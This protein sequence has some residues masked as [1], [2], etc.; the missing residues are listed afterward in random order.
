MFSFFFLRAAEP[1][2]VNDSLLLGD[3]KTESYLP[4]LQ[5]KRVA[6]FSNQTGRLS[7]GTHILDVLV[8]EKVEVTT[9]FSPE[10]GFRGNADAG[11]RVASSV[12]P[13][14]GI[15]ILSLYDGKRPG[16]SDE[17]MRRFDVL[18]VDIQDVGLR[19][20]TYYVTML[21]LMRRCSQ[22]G[23][24][25]VI[26]DRPN[27]NGHFVDG[28]ILDMSLKSGV[29]ALPIPIVHGMTLGELAFMATGEGWVP[30]CGL[31]VIPCSGYS[32]QSFYK[33]PVAPSPNLPNMASIYLYPSTCYFE[34]TC[35][36]L[37][38]GTDHPFQIYGHPD[39]QGCTYSFVPESRPGAKKP[40][41]LGEQCNGVDLTGISL[42]QLQKL[43]RIDL[44]YVV[45]AYRRMKD[46]EQFFLKN[47]FFDLLT[48]QRNIR[49][50]ILD[51]HSA[52]E[53]EATWKE[54]TARFREQRRK[55]LIYPE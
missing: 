52:Q 48:G 51:G 1:V 3:D 53:I 44:S 24:Q 27:P 19:F 28:P 49:Q 23:A 50:M 4:L 29:G 8:K 6:V 20:Y 11:E 16:P 21:Q 55:Y 47:K 35:V 18:V 40:P 26:L 34:G 2:W 10:H 5:G 30:P 31:T 42:F 37:G 54:D 9:L 39:M 43:S 17:A 32:H 46:K 15:P 7:D 25:V 22:S 36:S 14:T 38:R 45:D 12:D 41:L 13:D 33:L